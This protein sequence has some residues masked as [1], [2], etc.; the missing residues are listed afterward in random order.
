[1]GFGKKVLKWKP[2]ETEYCISILP[3]GGYVK[4]AGQE[5]DDQEEYGEKDF[6]NKKIWKRSL[7]VFA[8]PLA[9]Y[10][11]AVL[12]LWFV[13]ITG[14]RERP[15]FE[16]LTVGGLADTSAAAQAGIK[17]GDRLQSINNSR[18]SDWEDFYSRITVS[19]GRNLNLTFERD[20]KKQTIDVI[21]RKIHVDGIGSYG[22]LGVFSI[23]KAVVGQVFDGSAAKMSGVMAGDT[24]LYIENV[25][26]LSWQQMV[27]IVKSLNRRTSFLLKRKDS[28]FTVPLTPQYNETEKRFMIGIAMAQPEIQ[29]KYYGPFSAALKAVEK[30]NTIV[31]SMGRVFKGL[32][33]QSISPRSMAGPIGIVQMTGNAARMGKEALIFFMALISINLAVINL[34]PL[35]ITDGGV[36]L[37]LLIEKLRGKPLSLNVQ[38]RIQQVALAFFIFL[39]LFVT[40]NDIGR[41]TKFLF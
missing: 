9:N 3:L 5:A 16:N 12:V 40:V 34:L 27:T 20:G 41:F 33:V 31:V 24:V 26:I 4:L 30:S 38:M 23:E 15:D 22:D 21:P 32:F 8:G 13:F 37:F 36:L 11:F 25:K 18:I 14:V 10:L 39:F 29:R 28:T 6:R 19:G 35:A 1:V 2:H 17:I 7:I